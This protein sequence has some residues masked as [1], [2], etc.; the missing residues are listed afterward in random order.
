MHSIFDAWHTVAPRHSLRPIAIA[1]SASLGL[2]PIP[3]FAAPP[4]QTPAE[5]IDTEA[6]AMTAFNEGQAAYDRGEYKAALDLF[7]EAQS[8]YPSPVF[9]YN[10]GR[11]YEAL[12]NYEQAITSYN[13]YLRSTKSSTGSDPED[14]ANIENTIA[15]LEKLLEAEKAEDEAAR[16]KDPIVIVQDSGEGEP[17]HP[18][19]GLLITGGVLTVIGGG[20]LLIG[21]AVF[22]GQAMKVSK[23]LDEVYSGNPDDLTLAEAR[24]LDSQGRSAERNQ[25]I[26]MSIGSA[27]AVTGIALLVVGGLKA[28]RGKQAARDASP[29]QQP[30]ARLLPVL[31]PGNAGFVLQGR[32]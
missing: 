4:E 21:G 2:A 12:E 22:G 16:N 32:F 27:L 30:A 15:R 18:G 14:K 24:D 7:L 26:L 29:S 19:R 13:A 31:G 17:K 9:H 8:L 1:L 23:R 5:P 11:C 10:I 28:K 3:A 20:A 25:I 6:R